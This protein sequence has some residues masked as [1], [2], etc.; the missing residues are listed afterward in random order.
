LTTV[1]ASLADFPPP[2]SFHLVGSFLLHMLE[3]ACVSVHRQL[4]PG[5]PQ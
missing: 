3:E 2:N 5:V 1:E 4:K